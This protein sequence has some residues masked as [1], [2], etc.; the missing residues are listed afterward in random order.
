LEHYKDKFNSYLSQ[1]K[2]AILKTNLADMTPQLRRKFGRGG[3]DETFFAKYTANKQRKKAN[4]SNF[5]K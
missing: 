2:I 4:K 3:A 1:E 5:A